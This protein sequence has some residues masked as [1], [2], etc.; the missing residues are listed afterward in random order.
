[1]NKLGIALAAFTLCAWAGLGRTE[2]AGRYRLSGYLETY[3]Q[4]HSVENSGT[5]A[6]GTLYPRVYD[7]YRNQFAL[8]SGEV[9]LSGSDEAAGIAYNLN[10]LYG[11]KAMAVFGLRGELGQGSISKT[12]H[13]VKLTLGR[14]ATFIGT[15]VWTTA[16]NSNFSRGLLYYNEPFLF[17][18]LRADVSLGDFN[19]MAEIDN[20]ATGG[21]ALASTGDQGL[22]AALSYAGSKTWGLSL[23]WYKQPST[24]GGELSSNQYG[25]ALANVRLADS[26]SLNAEYLYVLALVAP[27]SVLP[28]SA[29]HGYAL[30]AN[31]SLPGGSLSLNARFEQLNQPD[32]G[33]LQNSY[34]ATLKFAEGALTHTLEY[35]ADANNNP[36]GGPDLSS[37]GL[38]Q[39][40]V[41]YAANY[42][43]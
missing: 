42:A 20:G 39:G 13:G 40:T 32:A 1:M 2:E 37:V 22:G 31:Y 11:E 28:Y 9:S 7:T 43:F 8:P 33:L 35:R 27:G 21:I 19:L 25:N 29:T 18:G 34:T 24:A 30:Y 3:Y 4:L 10:L 14:Q 17:N 38:A 12:I 6:P 15:E 5:S 16:S 36:A 26:F 23:A 41:T